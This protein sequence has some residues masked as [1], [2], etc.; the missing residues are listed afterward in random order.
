MEGVCIV[1]EFALLRERAYESWK[2]RKYRNDL[3]EE[4]M[5]FDAFWSWLMEKGYTEKHRVY[6]KDFMKP[7]GPDNCG[8]SI[9]PRSDCTDRSLIK[10][11]ERWDKTVAFFKRA[12]AKASPKAIQ[13]TVYQFGGSE[14]E[15]L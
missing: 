6:K 10:S 3:C 9:I 4:W 14:D 15:L 13:R 5:D 8:L 12:L 1:D 7:S 2:K 11:V